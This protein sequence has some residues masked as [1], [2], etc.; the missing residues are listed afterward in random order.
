MLRYETWDVFTDRRYAGNPL[1]VI[2]G[3]DVL[4]GEAM[5]RITRE[6]NYSESVFL[7]T[8]GTAECVARIRIFTPGGELPFAGHPTVG[9]AAAIAHRGRR[10]EPMMLE[11]S[12]GRFPV[13]VDNRGGDVWHAEFDNPNLPVVRARGP[14]AARVEAALGLPEDSVDTG[15]HAPRRCGAGIDFFYA[16]APLAAV[17]G[18]RLNTAAWDALGLGDAC[19]VLLYAPAAP[20][21]GSD[22]HVRM[23][24]PHIGVAEDPATGSAAAGL[25]AQLMAAGELADGDYDWQV[26]QGIEM[27][28]PARIRVR[29]EIRH[30]AFESLTIGGDA[31]R[32]CAGEIDC[33]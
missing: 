1:A 15:R 14:E 9:A 29:F 8:P 20:G 7:L 27:G 28:R 33:H 30:G 32:V 19:G 6:F 26:E 11:L 21:S 4:S 22:W 17:Q 25:P 2:F 3:A 18:A 31:I 16:A 12:A 13:R 5:L 24:G 23:F 10:D